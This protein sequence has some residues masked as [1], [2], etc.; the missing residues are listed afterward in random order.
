MAFLNSR[1][2]GDKV[3]PHSLGTP[4]KEAYKTATELGLWPSSI[5]KNNESLDPSAPCFFSCWVSNKTVPDFH[6]K[7]WLEPRESSPHFHMT[8]K[9]RA[10]P[11]TP[12]PHQ[13]PQGFSQKIQPK[14]SQTLKAFQV[15]CKG[16]PPCFLENLG[17]KNT[18]HFPYRIH[19]TFVYIY[20]RFLEIEDP[21]DVCIF[22]YMTWQPLGPRD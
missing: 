19:G 22:A 6:L 17:E 7:P 5:W 12:P 10:P 15:Q 13:P 20:Q 11:V 1:D 14:P 2:T 21:W 16:S 4:Y 9:L 18:H 3:I 8:R